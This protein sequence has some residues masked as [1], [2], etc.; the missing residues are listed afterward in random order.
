ML[1]ESK[2]AIAVD[3]T[4]NGKTEARV[5]DP[6]FSSPMTIERWA[7]ASG[8]KAPLRVESGPLDRIHA[9]FAGDRTNNPESWYTRHDRDWPA[10]S[11]AVLT[12]DRVYE[13]PHPEQQ[14][15]PSRAQTEQLVRKNVDLL[16]W[17]SIYTERR[18][19]ARKMW[20]IL[21]KS[22]ETDSPR[23]LY[24]RLEKLI[25]ERPRPETLQGF[26]EDYPGILS[27][28]TARIPDHVA[29]ITRR[30]PDGERRDLAR[31]MWDV[32]KKSKETDSPATCTNV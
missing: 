29:A 12:E 4:V 28:L 16:Y 13:F 22:K 30:F 3:V 7:S 19:L 18:S 14:H 9:D 17:Q 24:E 8:A 6:E 1:R 23:H 20:D 2:A 27:A 21:E 10:K 31:K 15:L 11:T 26:W 25:P 32:L 5:L